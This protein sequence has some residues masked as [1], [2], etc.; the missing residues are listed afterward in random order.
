MTLTLFF[1][2]VE[3]G[4]LHTDKMKNFVLHHAEELRKIE[5][6]LDETMTVGWDLDSDPISL[7]L[8]P[9]EQT[10]MLELIKTKSK[11]V[12]KVTLVF[13]SLCQ[14]IENLCEVVKFFVFF[15]FFLNFSVFSSFLFVFFGILTMN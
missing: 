9:H 3:V 13:A 15:L 6:A 10:T 4:Q 8:T 2:S 14:E 7:D 12:T 1:I 11:P 5:S